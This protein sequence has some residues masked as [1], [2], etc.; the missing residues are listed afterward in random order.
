[1]MNKMCKIKKIVKQTHKIYY[2][3]MMGRIIEMKT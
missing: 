3:P 1:M 2:F